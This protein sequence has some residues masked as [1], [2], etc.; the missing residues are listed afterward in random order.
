MALDLGLGG[1]GGAFLAFKAQAQKWQTNEGGE[2]I[3]L[4]W[5][6]TIWRLDEAQTGWSRW[7]DGEA[8]DWV[9]DDEIGKAGPE[10]T[11]EGWQRGFQVSVQLV[12]PDDKTYGEPMIFNSTAVGAKLGFQALYSEYEEQAANNPGKVPVVKNNG[13]TPSK[14]TSIPKLTIVRWIDKP[15]N[16]SDTRF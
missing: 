10:P 7:P 2:K 13:V 1:N 16:G 3:N 8:R 15:A 5:T 6:H 11:G 14:R 4:D 12:E 9:W